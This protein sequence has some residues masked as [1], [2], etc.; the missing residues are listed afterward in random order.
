MI[1]SQAGALDKFISSKKQK[2]SSN[3]VE[4]QEIL[5]NEEEEI[6]VNEGQENLGNKGQENLGN[7]EHE[8]SNGQEGMENDSRN[9]DMSS[10]HGLRNIDD[11][12][13]WYQIDQKFI[14][15]L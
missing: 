4:E 3:L 10:E 8:E 14:D 15:S 6:L 2:E 13:N 9:E 11:P 5:V 7:K 1:Q 12:S